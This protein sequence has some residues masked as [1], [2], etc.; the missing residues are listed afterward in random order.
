MKRI[1]MSLCCAAAV[2]AAAGAET[3]YVAETGK[4]D[5]PGTKDAP[6]LTIQKAADLMQPGD[7][8]VVGAGTYRETVRPARSG[9]PDKPIVFRPEHGASVVVSG[10]E[11]VATSQPGWD[12]DDQG[13]YRT[14]FQR[15]SA[16]IEQLF[17]GGRMLTM[18]RWPNAKGDLLDPAWAEA[19]DGTEAGKIVDAALPAIDPAGATIHVLPGR[20]WVSWTRPVQGLDPATHTLSFNAD[21]SQEDAYRVQPGTRYYLFG[22]AALMDAPGE[23]CASGDEIWLYPPE[24]ESPPRRVFD[25]EAKARQWAFDLSG[26]SHVRVA[27]FQLFA[28]SINLADAAHCEVGGCHLRY[29]THFTKTDGWTVPDSGVVIGGHHNVFRG[30]SVTYSAGNGITLKGEHNTVTNCLVRQVDYM[31]LDAGAVWAEGRGHTISFNTLRDA[32]RSVLLHRKLKAGTIEYND[33]ARAGRLT[34]DL[35]ATYCF[36]TDGEGTVIAYNRVHDNLAEHVGV[37]IY[38]DNGSANFLIHHN[39]CWNNPD[40]GIRLNTPS[41]NNRVYHNTVTRNGNA[42]GL[43]GPDNNREQ[44]GCEIVNNIFTDK[45]DTGNGARVENN[46]TGPDPGFL[47]P[48]GGEFTLKPGSPCIDAGVAI[49]AISDPTEGA[50]PDLGAHETGLGAWR[51]GHNWGDPPPSPGR[52]R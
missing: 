38:I 16:P 3:Y 6:F 24:G 9:E 20:R 45:V 51:A 12:R 11:P 37:G 48:L 36:Q 32:G 49:P 52:N 26:L 7:V 13:R 47:W 18:A 42:I 29:A 27:G 50:A 40:S 22:T 1:L 34:T 46:F 17:M 4:P 33:I 8:C 35:G 21:W 5:N 44:P 30:S 39:V 31:A 25:V 10:T 41:I 15:A 28:A 2:T 19:D 23:W 43:W 14:K